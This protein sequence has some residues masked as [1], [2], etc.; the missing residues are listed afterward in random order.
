MNAFYCDVIEEKKRGI[1]LKYYN[2][3][4]RM[5]YVQGERVAIIEND[6]G[7]ASTY[8]VVLMEFII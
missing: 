4:L 7:N 1:T 2:T 8:V 5:E 3:I 6:K